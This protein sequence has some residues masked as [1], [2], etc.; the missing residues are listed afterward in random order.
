MSLF[1]IALCESAGLAAL[2]VSR[3]G[4]SDFVRSEGLQPF[5]ML[6]LKYKLTFCFHTITAGER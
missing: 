3:S 2:Y 5:L 1:F 4:R 6:Q